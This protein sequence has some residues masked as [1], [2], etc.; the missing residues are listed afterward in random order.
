MRKTLILRIISI[1]IVF[2]L[3]IGLGVLGFITLRNERL[4]IMNYITWNEDGYFEIE[5]GYFETKPL[6]WKLVLKETTNESGK[7]DFESTKNYTETTELSGSYYFLLNTYIPFYMNCSEANAYDWNPDDP[8]RTDKYGANVPNNEYAVSNIR[9]FLNGEDVWRSY[10][11]E[12]D[13]YTPAPY[14]EGDY[15]QKEKDNFLDLFH[16]KES[17]IY[18]LIEGR[19][20]EELYSTAY[21]SENNEALEYNEF[22]AADIPSS[23]KDKLWLLS[24]YEAYKMDDTTLKN[25]KFRNFDYNY[26][27]RSPF[28]YPINYYYQSYVSASGYMS[29]IYNAC[30]TN[31]CRPAFKVTL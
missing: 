15:V 28:S 1:V 12:N 25:S 16:I 22:V 27:L 18:N 13:I 3:S 19:S 5:M 7:L 17:H 29:V 11:K 14:T 10:Y 8:T 20:L 24:W 2:C 4:N 6:K 9:A 30:F 31:L 26:W 21:Q 23:T